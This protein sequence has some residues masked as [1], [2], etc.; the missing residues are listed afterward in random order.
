[1]NQFSITK[2][3]FFAL[4]LTA[5]MFAQTSCTKNECCPTTAPTR[6]YPVSGLWVGTFTTISGFAQPPGT[7]YY[8]ALSLYPD[9]KMS[10]KSGTSQ[11][12]F[13]VYAEGT[14][15]LSGTNLSWTA[16]TINAQSGSQVAVNGSATYMPT[17]DTLTNGIVTTS[18]PATRASWTTVR[19]N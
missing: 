15:S 14:W 5:I 17:S 2:R 9:G 19:V 10:Y 13:F 11:S 8:L 18:N 12:G 4:L 7:S 3:M 1:M 16:T 6:T